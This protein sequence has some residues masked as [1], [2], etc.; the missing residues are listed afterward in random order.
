MV[1]CI[2]GYIY[3][4]NRYF[5]ILMYFEFDFGTINRWSL[6]ETSR[7]MILWEESENWSLVDFMVIMWEDNS[8]DKHWLAFKNGRRCQWTK[9]EKNAW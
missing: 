2:G 5:D 9:T 4:Y 6:G 3:V 8:T 7:A 1:I